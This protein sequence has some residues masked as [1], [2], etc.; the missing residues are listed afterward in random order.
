[1]HDDTKKLLLS[2]GIFIGKSLLLTAAASL[3]LTLLVWLVTFV[4]NVLSSFF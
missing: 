3:F 4:S 2:V 1:M